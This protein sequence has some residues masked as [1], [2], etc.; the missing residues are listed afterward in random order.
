MI[1]PNNGRQTLGNPF[2]LNMN[3]LDTLFDENDNI[4]SSVLKNCNYVDFDTFILENIDYKNKFS[5]YSN[6]IRSLPNKWNDF[7][8]NIED[9]SL[10][11]FKFSVICLQEIWNIPPT[12]TPVLPGY[13]PIVY[14]IRDSTGR[15]M[16]SGGAWHFLLIIIMILRLL[17]VYLSLYLACLNL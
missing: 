9:F 16:N 2:H 15:N 6:N 7:L 14:N 13:K 3:L 10:K 1:G 17:K 5:V 11:D 4:E 8:Q 12:F